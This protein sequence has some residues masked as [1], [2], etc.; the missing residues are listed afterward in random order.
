MRGTRTPP[1]RSGET[2]TPEQLRLR[3]VQVDTHPLIQGVQKTHGH[4]NGHGSTPRCCPPCS[5][6]DDGLCHVLRSGELGQV[7]HIHQGMRRAAAHQQ[8]VY[9]AFNPPREYQ[10]SPKGVSRESPVNPKMT[11]TS[12]RLVHLEGLPPT[13]DRSIDLSIDLC[14][15]ASCTILERLSPVYQSRQ[16][17]PLSSEPFCFFILNSFFSRKKSIKGI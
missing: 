9:V 14:I 11:D 5:S 1:L 4:L 12:V 8:W 3:G 6:P 13:A 10:E 17:S 15:H 16:T 7:D 2:H